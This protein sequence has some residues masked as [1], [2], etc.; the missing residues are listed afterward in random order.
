MADLI[1]KV[2]N[3]EVF[4]M[5]PPVC[6]DIGAAGGLP[7]EWE[8][9]ASRSICVA[10]DADTRDFTVDESSTGGWKRLIRLNRIVSKEDSPNIQF[11]LTRSPHCSSTLVPDNKALEPWAFHSLFKVERTI[12]LSAVSLP[13][14]LQ[15]LGITGIDWYKT[16]S[17]GT[18]LR[19]FSSLGDNLIN[20]IIVADFEPEIINCYHDEDKLYSL[21]EFMDC[22]PF[23][24][25]DMEIKGS[26][27]V[28]V[29]ALHRL[30]P[31]QKRF[32]PS[33]HKRS[34]GWCGIS[35]INSQ[36]SKS[37]RF[38]LLAWIFSTIKEQYGH[39]LS[40]AKIG[41]D[42]CGDSLFSEC[43]RASVRRVEPGFRPMARHILLKVISK[44]TGQY[45]SRRLVTD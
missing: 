12:T 1:S 34:P 25:S 27:R 23:F 4:D 9:I 6:I 18:D 29:E 13:D 40:I 26:H 20:S 24:V 38:L 21:M 43:Y 19:I 30:G 11:Y 37:K 41:I 44:L 8:P 15:E 5:E 33:I 31:L 16:D 36:I 28:P 39:A 17:Q 42:V 2:L 7:R 35:Y 10:F 32:F 45:K 14:V 22:R 3:S